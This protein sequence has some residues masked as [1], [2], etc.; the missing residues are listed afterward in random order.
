[1]RRRSLHFTVRTPHE[2]VLDIDVVSLRVPTASGQVG[3]RPRHEPL[4]LA[5]ETGLV[6]MKSAGRVRFAGTAGGL[7]V[8]DGV[9]ATL[10]TPL[11]AVGDDEA[12]VLEALDRSLREP[13]AD[14][15]GR[16]ALGQLES[17]ILEEMRH[18]LHELRGGGGGR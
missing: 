14:L 7:L 5:V 18:G 17:R 10:L 12:G 9:S 3:L 2:V 15:R 13:D 8:S 16:T 4:T 1:M 11:A 6:V